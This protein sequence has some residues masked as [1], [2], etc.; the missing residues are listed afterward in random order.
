MP[1]SDTRAK[2]IESMIADIGIDAASVALGI[3]R[4][5]ARR[6]ARAARCAGGD[7][8]TQDSI[9]RKIVERYTPEELKKIANGNGL[10]TARSKPQRISF[11]GES[12]R[13]GFCTDTH[14][15][16]ESF[17]DY[18][19]ELF[20]KEC[21]RQSV[22]MIFHAGDLIEGMSNRSDHVYHL[23]DI[24]FSKQMD[25]AE[26]LLAMTSIPI[27][28]IDGNHDRWGIKSGGILAVRDIANRLD[29]VDFIGHDTG[30]VVINES[31]W[32]LWHG[33]DGSSYATSYRIQ[34]LIEAFTGGD[35][36]SV[37]LC[38]HTHKQGYFFERN[39]HAVSGGALSYQSSW[40]R[41]TR[42]ACHTGFWI[43]TATIRDGR[44]VRFLP[45]WFPIYE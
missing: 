38:G 20:I 10:N 17:S 2:E 45:E 7:V 44:I 25:H 29:H 11:D 21:E 15:G 3:S 30:D 42:K 1:I 13:V 5:S 4:E 41:A 8:E 32:R 6:Y 12:V 9:V 43:I 37:L 33:E 19:W 26:E 28:I 39:I 27:K 18:L 23:T 35:K 24:G 36:P 22:D 40:M 14:V 31:V 34:K 16:E